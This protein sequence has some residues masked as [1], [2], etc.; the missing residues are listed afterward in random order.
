MISTS[1][2]IK[3]GCVISNLMVNMNPNNIKLRARAINML[4]ALNGKSEDECK[5]LLENNGWSIRKALEEK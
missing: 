4:S 2:F 5:A 3:Y 1:L